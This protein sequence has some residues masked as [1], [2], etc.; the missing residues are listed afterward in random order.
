M[1]IFLDDLLKI[2][3][4]EKEEMQMFSIFKWPEC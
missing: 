1:L 3:L 2:I 4:E